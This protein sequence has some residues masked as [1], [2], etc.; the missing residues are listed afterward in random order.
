MLCLVLGPAALTDPSVLSLE[1]DLPEWWREQQGQGAGELTWRCEEDV[2]L[3]PPASRGREHHAVLH[4][5][6]PP[7]LAP[8]PLPKLHG[9]HRLA[10]D[11]GL[12]GHSR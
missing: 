2:L 1:S 10:G 9:S 7:A 6:G 5:G 8:P 3:V 4:P 11:Q 12:Q